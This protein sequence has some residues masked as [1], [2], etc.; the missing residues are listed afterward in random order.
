MEA[1]TFSLSAGSYKA[2]A[3]LELTTKTR[4]AEI[5]Y[6]TDGE[7]P[8][9]KSIKY[10]APINL[11]TSQ[12]IKALAV[13]AKMHPSTV[14]TANYVIAIESFVG[15]GKF[16]ING[17]LANGFI[18]DNT[19]LLLHLDGTHN[20]T[21][22]SDSARSHGAT[23][24][25]TAARISSAQSKFGGSSVYFDGSSGIQIDRAADLAFGGATQDFT[26][27]MWLY[28]T[29]NHGYN[30]FFEARAPNSGGTP[31]F[32]IS[33]ADKSSTAFEN[34]IAFYDEIYGAPIPS[35]AGIALNT[36]SHFA[37]VR[38][39]STITYY[40]N[41]V[42]SGSQTSLISGDAQN[43]SINEGY[44]RLGAVKDGYDDDY[45]YIG[46]MDEVR[47]T[48]GLARY[49]ANFTPASSAFDSLDNSEGCYVAGVKTND[50]VNGS[51]YCTGDQTYYIVRNAMPGLNSLGTGLSTS[52]NKYYVNATLATG[53]YNN[54]CYAQGMNT[55]GVVNGTGY[56]IA[57]GKYY[58]QGI[59][60]PGLDSS[61]NGI[62]P[63]DGRFYVRG[64]IANGFV[65]DKIVLLLHMDGPEGSATFTDSSSHSHLITPIGNAII[66]T[67]QSKFG[68]AS[69]YFDGDGDRLDL[70][71][72]SDF[73]LETGDYTIEFFANIQ[74][75]SGYDSARLFTIENGYESWGIIIHNDGSG[76][77]SVNHYGVPV[78]FEGTGV[79]NGKIGS[80]VHF[81][82]VRSGETRTLYVDGMNVGSMNSRVLPNGASQLSTGGSTIAFPYTRLNAFIDEF[83]ISKGIARYTSNF[84]PPSA[85]FD[86]SDS[87]AGCYVAGVKTNA[88]VNGSGYCAGDETYYIAGTAMPGLNSSGTGLST[89]D[90]KYYANG[91][92]ANGFYENACYAQG[93]NTGGVV[94][95]TGYCRSASG[96][97]PQYN[98]YYGNGASNAVQVTEPI[99]IGFNEDFTIDFWFYELD[100]DTSANQPQVLMVGSNNFGVYL[101]DNSRNTFIAGAAGYFTEGWYDGFPA[102]NIWHHLAVSRE[103]GTLRLF[104]D[105]DLK[106]ESSFSESIV[107]KVTLGGFDFAGFIDKLRITKGLARYTSTFAPPSAEFESTDSSEGCYVA[108]VK[109]NDVVNGS[110]YCVGDQTYYIKRSGMPGLNSS[111]TGL[112]TSDNKCYA[113]GVNTGGV[114]DGT[115]YC[116]ADG[117]Y[118]V[119]GIAQPWPVWANI[120]IDDNYGVT[121]VNDVTSPDDGKVRIYWPPPQIDGSGNYMWGGSPDSRKYVVTGPFGSVDVSAATNEYIVALPYGVAATFAVKIVSAGGEGQGP[122]ITYTPFQP[123]PSAPT[124]V[125]VTPGD[126]L[127]TVTFDFDGK[128]GISPLEFFNVNAEY[129]GFFF[130]STCVAGCDAS[131]GSKT[132]TIAN[133]TNG[134]TYSVGI[135]A[136]GVDP[137]RQTNV[138]ATGTPA[139]QCLDFTGTGT[140]GS[141]YYENGLVKNPQNVTRYSI[142]SDVDNSVA[143][144]TATAGNFV[145][146]AYRSNSNIQKRD[147]LTGALVGSINLDGNPGS[148]LLLKSG[149]YIWAFSGTQVWRIHRTTNAVTTLSPMSATTYG[150]WSSDGYI[151]LSTL[152]GSTPKLIKLNGTSGATENTVNL[153]GFFTDGVYGISGDA[154]KI[155][156][157]RDNKLV[158]FD[159]GTLG[160]LRTVN[161]PDTGDFQS[162]LLWMLIKAGDGWFMGGDGG[163]LYRYDY[164]T[165]TGAFLDVTI[166]S[167][168]GWEVDAT[169]FWITSTWQT[170]YGY[171][172]HVKFDGSVDRRVA[173]ETLYGIAGSYA[174]V[175]V[176]PG[177]KVWI[178][179]YYS[180]TLLILDWLAN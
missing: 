121:Q 97:I 165:D 83:R 166:N 29:E 63:N 19:V 27:E 125:R 96:Y 105:G 137:Y 140:C 142:P 175:Q 158:F 10:S 108:G 126:G 146:L 155:A 134:I 86:P 42:A 143:D 51:G 36:W 71:T 44:I 153:S 171:L 180:Q 47:I 88:V 94:N 34:G 75:T 170:D 138:T 78:G 119:Q 103:S 160:V 100:G 93:Y 15:D 107:G 102:K 60:Q 2:G 174:K 92:R 151:W 55:G 109:T 131:A 145:W 49:T 28:P 77:V 37:L 50:V 74:D 13:K 163:R 21:I 117:K 68:G 139:P 118:Y 41:G 173:L 98:S 150:G 79:L 72:T 26:I 154:S 132:F 115:G 89:S 4:D 147:I 57:D 178:S 43:P 149:E 177:G 127:L 172:Y 101:H 99:N 7:T 11:L 120:A 8:T 95:G 84:M 85:A 40:I 124:N 61:G 48:K 111:G 104:R 18:S 52:N 136:V 114:V 161:L 91:T 148:P 167:I 73:D 156:L 5:Y 168:E 56:C 169:G 87:S 38:H 53:F 39:G 133:L 32:G 64:V 67:S 33:A 157:T 162:G 69:A 82:L 123:F 6:T 25:G 144:E 30:V 129:N 58:I 59:E 164:Q 135:G 116:I 179:H 65:K 152:D 106:E 112:S 46:Y 54:T 3:K 110:G 20:S 45:N 76:S 14:V 159:K 17:A 24:D 35:T 9:E 23:V 128:S 90:N 113:Q 1:P 22:I 70:G 81:A 141:S 62:N 66:S 16:Y 12:T 176:A 80:W 122:A 130:D 31:G